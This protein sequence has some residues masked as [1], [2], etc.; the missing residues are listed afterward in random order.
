MNTK[1][2]YF[3]LH[4][5]RK[6]NTIAKLLLKNGRVGG[7]KPPLLPNLYSLR[8]YEAAEQA[9]K[10]SNELSARVTLENQSLPSG[11]TVSLEELMVLSQFWPCNIQYTLG[12]GQPSGASHSTPKGAPS[13]TLMVRGGSSLKLFNSDFLTKTELVVAV[14]HS[15]VAKHWYWP[16]KRH[17]KQSYLRSTSANGPNHLVPR[18]FPSNHAKKSQKNHVANSIVSWSGNTFWYGY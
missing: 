8:K 10:K 9:Y 4:Y 11:S 13:S 17:G 7:V 14:P 15:L 16:G 12:F 2:C 18:C 6:Y 5:P 3:S 1:Q